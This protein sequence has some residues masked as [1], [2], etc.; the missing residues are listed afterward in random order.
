MNDKSRHLTMIGL[1]LGV[2]LASLDQTITATALPA[3]VGELGGLEKMTWIHSSYLLASTAVV[4]VVGKLS[5]IFGRRLWYLIGLATFIAGS[6]LCGTAGS[7]TQL[8]LFRGLQGLGGGMLMPVTMTVIGDIFPGSER[9]KI[10]G[11]LA[12]TFGISSVMGPKVGG[13][14]VDLWNWRWA[15]WINLPL[16]FLAAAIVALMLRESRNPGRKVIDYWGSITFTAGVSL[17]ILALV[18]GGRTQAWSSPDIL[19]FLTGAAVLL[20]LFA[21]IEARSP[22]PILDV[23]LF[24]NRVF[25]VSNALVFLMGS[26]MF[27]ALLFV[28]LFIQGV[29]GA[30]ASQAGSVMTPMMLGVASSSLIGGRLMTRTSFRSL[31]TTGMAM[32]SIGF[33]LL[34]L[35]TTGTSIGALT[36]YMVLTG[37]G[38]GLVMPTTVIAV[39][40][41]FPAE[42]R[43]VVTSS[44][45]FSRSIG[46]TLGVS[47]LGAVMNSRSATEITGRLGQL[48]GSLPVAVAPA[49]EPLR[50]LAETTPQRLFTLLLKPEALS[51][52]PGP[53]QGP[54]AELLR[55]SLTA[56]VHVVFLVSLVLSLLGLAVSLMMGGARLTAAGSD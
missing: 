53:V 4:P 43:G 15:F 46:G 55:Q 16:G 7:M 35:M 52:L 12:G 50:S 1:M 56:S 44:V 13:W 28:P 37:I 3:I 51:A 47:I 41:T 22:D 49:L 42:R 18:E 45:A 2:L 30:S 32:T 10:Q 33:F 39:Q 21:W 38:F 40:N 6:A 29:L 5:D 36:A 31:L 48:A 34:S 26:G 27:G 24:R 8:I 19:G 11:Y 23:S 54:L 17:L 20:A 9:A 25:L 14:I